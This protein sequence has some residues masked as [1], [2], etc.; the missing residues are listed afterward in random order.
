MEVERVA[1][2]EVVGEG[3]R[4]VQVGRQDREHQGLATQKGGQ[5]VEEGQSQVKCGGAFPMC[6]GSDDDDAFWR[7][8]ALEGTWSL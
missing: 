3:G 4:H 7:H 2:Y 1:S 8:H 6:A 5:Q